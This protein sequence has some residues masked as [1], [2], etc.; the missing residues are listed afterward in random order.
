VTYSPDG[1]LLAAVCSIGGDNFRTDLGEVKVWDVVAGK[2]VT[3]FGGKGV[4]ATSV[5]FSPSDRLLAWGRSGGAA[6]IVVEVTTW[7]AVH[8]LDGLKGDVQ[9][10]AFSPD[11]KRLVAAGGAW[12]PPDQQTNS[13]AVW[14]WDLGTGKDVAH[15]RE[16]G[17]GVSAV[18]FSPNGQMLASGSYDGAVRL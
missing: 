9:S 8:T 5:E 17:G 14:L 6:A 16:P 7:K 11:G 12:D 10:L 1:K 13:G 4:G 3:A 15:W 2:V 18:V